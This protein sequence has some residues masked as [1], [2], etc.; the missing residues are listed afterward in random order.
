[1]KSFTRNY[2]G[3]PIKTN[4]VMVP[5]EY[6]ELD[7]KAVTNPE[8]I[9]SITVG[10]KR[11]RVIYKAVDQAWEKDARAA[12]N[13]YQNE[14]LGYY[15]VPNSVSR[16]A[17]EDEYELDLVSVPSAEDIIMAVES[18]KETINT[19]VDLVSKVIEKSPKIGYAVLL[20]HAGVKDAEFYDKMRLSSFP[21]NRVR[22]EAEE[23][24]K[25]GLANFDVESYK[26]HNSKFDDIYKEEAYALLKVI[27]GMLG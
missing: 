26:G 16:D 11:F 2:N 15:A 27:I 19:F 7:A 23:I 14:E 9:S 21:G 24:L 3:E 10:K 22:K 20:L 12:F 5:F 4:E 18:A 25:S 1:M 6:T 17:M 13:L 8:C